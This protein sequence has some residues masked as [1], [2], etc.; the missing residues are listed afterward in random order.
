MVD[1]VGALNKTRKAI[2]LPI[3]R[4][5]RA[6]QEPDPDELEDIEETLIGSDVP[7]QLAMEWAETLEKHYCGLRTGKRDA[8]SRLLLREL[9][10]PKFPERR[11]NGPLC[12]LLVGVNG[13]GK[14]TT[15]A[16]LGRYFRQQGWHPVLGAADTFRAAGSEQL[17]RWG[18]RLGLPVVTGA[19]G[20]DASA[21]AYD[22]LDSAI[23]RKADVVL[24]DTAGRMHTK[25]PLMDELKKMARALEKRLPGAPHEVWIVLDASTGANAV[26]QAR[27]FNACLP[28]TGIIAAKLDGSSRAGFLF[29]VY[30][31]LQ[32]PVVFAGLGEGEDDLT[33]FSP[34][35]FV[36]ALF[37]TESS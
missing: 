1:W 21:V 7:P 6:D 24:I 29:S 3:A 19:P 26:S 35:D 31:E 30:R 27:F 23:A 33:L 13:T 18:E 12:I 14:T 28:L 4:W 22:T 2:T 32:A 10:E 36:N 25:Q 11:E 8:L 5:F 9:P 34:K 20:A 37:I 16:K 17:N 15:C